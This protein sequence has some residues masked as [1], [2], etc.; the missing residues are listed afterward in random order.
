MDE[1]HETKLL[2][3]T[4]VARRLSISRPTAYRRVWEGSLPAYRL[5]ETGPLRVDETELEDWLVKRRL[6]ERS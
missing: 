1:K 3:I 4:E 5:G 6:P 2:P